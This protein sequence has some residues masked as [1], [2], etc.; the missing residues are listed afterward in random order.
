MG[1]GFAQKAAAAPGPA[2]DA[3][4]D[5]PR[6]AKRPA[7]ALLKRPAA[8]NKKPA[9]AGHDGMQMFNFLRVLYITKR[10]WVVLHC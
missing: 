5:A 4:G 6:V 7:G 1:V 9:A 10:R 3:G 2:G 8:A